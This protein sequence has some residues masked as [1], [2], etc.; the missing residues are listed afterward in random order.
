MNRYP[1]WSRVSS[2]ARAVLA[3]IASAVALALATGCAHDEQRGSPELSPDRALV[4]IYLSFD[5][6][7]GVTVEGSVW[8]FR[9]A[10]E[11]GE[12]AFDGDFQW[13][14]P[15]ITIDI[16]RGRYRVTAYERVCAGNCA[17]L[18]PPRK[19]CSLV[20]VA[21]GGETYEIEGRVTDEKCSLR[22]T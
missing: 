17:V 12:R 22:I 20:F 7:V 9:V 14:T 3:G 15:D 2:R 19:R 13:A 10:H 8:R 6:G 21:R 1:L 11:T 18:E 4:R 16:P 5:Y